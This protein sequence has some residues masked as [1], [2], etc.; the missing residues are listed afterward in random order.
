M[1]STY[2]VLTSH[3]NRDISVEISKLETSLAEAKLWDE[4][5]TYQLISP[6]FHYKWCFIILREDWEG[7]PAV[8]HSYRILRNVKSIN[9]YIW[10]VGKCPGHPLLN[11]LDPTPIL[12]PLSNAIWWRMAYVCCLT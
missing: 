1:T 12:S 2:A 7:Y 9:L 6:N 5:F 10:Q 11:F 3:S 4:Y 8:Y